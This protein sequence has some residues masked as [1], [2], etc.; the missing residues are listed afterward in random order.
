M[1]RQVIWALPAI[2]DLESAAEYIA[3]DSESYAASFV[4][5]VLRAAESLQAMAER[6]LVVPEMG[7]PGIREP[8]VYPIG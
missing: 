7:D 3:T 4:Q 6:G 5:D 8:L 2:D 1:A